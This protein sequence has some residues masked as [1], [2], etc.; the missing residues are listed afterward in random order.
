VKSEGGGEGVG[1]GGGGSYKSRVIREFMILS[2]MYVVGR[3]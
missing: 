1:G 3:I 2:C